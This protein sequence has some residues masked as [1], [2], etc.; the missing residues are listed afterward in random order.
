MRSL[1]LINAK[2]T[3]KCNIEKI[4]SNHRVDTDEDMSEGFN[5]FPRCSHCYIEINIAKETEGLV[6][7]SQ[8]VEKHLFSKNEMYK[9]V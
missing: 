8:A 6:R 4:R 9:S 1:I 5:S 3:A 2:V 7:P